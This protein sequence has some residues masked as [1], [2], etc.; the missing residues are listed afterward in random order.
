MST[1]QSKDG[2]AIV[3]DR[4]GDGPPVI[5][6]DGAFC[7]RA[8]GPSKRLAELLAQQFTVFTYDRRGR[9]GSGDTAPYAVEREVEDLQALIEEAGG[10][11]YVS[12]I[13]SGAALALEAAARGSAITKLAL[14]EAPFIVDD[15]RPPIP[16][17]IVSQLNELLTA[18]RRGDAVRLF[19]RQMG[20]PRLIVAL[21]RLLPVWSKL[22][23]VAHTLPYD[24]TILAGKQAGTPLPAGQW[25]EV[26]MPALVVVGGKSPAWFHHGTRAL[27]QALPNADHRVLE[28]QMHNVKA[29][30]LAPLLAEFFTA[31]ARPAN[32]DLAA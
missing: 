20:A 18:D 13:S 15:S 23:G 1:V 16:A 27:A 25:V 8:V 26:T 30:A 22:T 7:Y 32:A 14:Y 31:D 5:L 24:F 6:V 19:L 4:S 10:S 29:K 28:G 2:T 21:M 11:A 12:G 3:F 17:D 9:G